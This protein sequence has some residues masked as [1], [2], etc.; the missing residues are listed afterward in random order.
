MWGKSRSSFYPKQH[1]RFLTPHHYRREIEETTFDCRSFTTIFEGRNSWLLPHSE[2]IDF[3]RPKTPELLLEKEPSEFGNGVSEVLSYSGEPNSNNQLQLVAPRPVRPNSAPLMITARSEDQEAHHYLFGYYQSSRDIPQSFYEQRTAV[4][5][6]QS[7]RELGSGNNFGHTVPTTQATQ[8]PG[9]SNEP[10]GTPG[11]SGYN[12]STQQPGRSTEPLGIPGPSGFNSRHSGSSSTGQPLG[13]P[14]PSSAVGSRRSSI[15]SFNPDSPEFIPGAERHTSSAAATQPDS[16]PSR[17][18]VKRRRHNLFGITTS[19]TE[20]LRRA[21]SIT[22]APRSTRRLPVRVVAAIHDASLAV[23]EERQAEVPTQDAHATGNRNILFDRRVPLQ[24]V[25]GRQGATPNTRENPDGNTLF[26]RRVPHQHVFGNQGRATPNP[27]QDERNVNHRNTIPPAVRHQNVRNAH[28]RN[29]LMQ[30]IYGGA[31]VPRNQ[32]TVGPNGEAI[33]HLVPVPIP[34]GALLPPPPG[35]FNATGGAPVT[36]RAR[37]PFD[38]PAR[39]GQFNLFQMGGQTPGALNQTPGNVNMM[40]AGPP[41]TPGNMGAQGLPTADIRGNMGAQGLPTADIRGNMGAQGVG[42]PTPGQA[43]PQGNMG[44]QGLPTPGQAFPQLPPGLDAPWGIAGQTTVLPG[45]RHPEGNRHVVIPPGIGEAPPQMPLENT[46][47]PQFWGQFLPQVVHTAPVTPTTPRTG[48]QAI[49]GNAMEPFLTDRT[50]ETRI[51]R[52]LEEE[53]ARARRLE[54]EVQLAAEYVLH[55][56][57]VLAARRE[58]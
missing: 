5:G 37:N 17:P 3:V 32:F 47:P 2:E 38:Q 13:V 21:T 26:D 10:L 27:N 33:R 50:D 58:E 56:Q 49:A 51:A 1:T 53:R 15:S 19:S 54:A 41:N 28:V 43:F 20:S 11:P 23:P 39:M 4:L 31:Q 29:T 25:I 22:G 45:F 12:Q 36:G 18:E 8:Q 35:N 46:P 44:A 7:S 55:L 24:Y 52:Q 6:N 34:E 14:G 16:P 40:P 9:R 30:H 57:D 42:L 48:L